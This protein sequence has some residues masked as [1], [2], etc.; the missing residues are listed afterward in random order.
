MSQ[1]ELRHP[2]LTISEGE[3]WEKLGKFYGRFALRQ[4]RW[5]DESNLREYGYTNDGTRVT[6]NNLLG[7]NDFVLGLGSI[8]P[9]RVCAR[10]FRRIRGSRLGHGLF[11]LE[12]GG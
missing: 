9:H 12:Q 1:R 8:V 4:H 10:A 5:L 2:C 11:T 3:L 6:A 7:E